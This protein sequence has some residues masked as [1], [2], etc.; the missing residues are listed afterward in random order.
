MIKSIVVLTDGETIETFVGTGIPGPWTGNRHVAL[1]EY[2]QRSGDKSSYIIEDVHD[3]V[4]F[5]RPS[6]IPPSPLQT[7][8]RT[9][10]GLG[11][12][13]KLFTL[14]SDVT[15]LVEQ[16]AAERG[17]YQSTTVAR[18]IREFAAREKA[19]DTPLALPPAHH[20][21]TID[22]E[23]FVAVPR[24]VYEVQVRAA[25]AAGTPSTS[26]NVGA[27]RARKVG[28]DKPPANEGLRLLDEAL[29]R[30]GLTVLEAADRAQ[31]RQV[32]FVSLVNNGERAR[33]RMAM[34]LHNTFGIPVGSW[35]EPAHA[36]R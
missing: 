8:P 24:M 30:E 19:A 20:A 17:E 9:R 32:E 21:L 1:R 26:S 18:A 33:G 23:A 10:H 34:N 29:R 12:E 4:L 15:E 36:V 22:G 7:P 16:L 14:P 27:A 35:N 6:P 25:L 5:L 28:L 11:G 3:G 13:K 2:R 31:V